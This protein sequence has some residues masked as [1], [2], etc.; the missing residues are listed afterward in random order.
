M[1]ST[2][3]FDA[4]LDSSRSDNVTSFARILSEFASSIQNFYHTS[5]KDTTSVMMLYKPIHGFSMLIM[6]MYPR[7]N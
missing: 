4:R 6:I 2:L 3:E 5:P 1:D 7:V